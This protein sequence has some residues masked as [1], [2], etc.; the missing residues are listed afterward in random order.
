MLAQSAAAD[1]MAHPASV[2]TG[3]CVEVGDVVG[4]LSDVVGEATGGPAMGSA[5]A[6]AVEASTT[7]TV[8]VS[9][10]RVLSL[11]HSVV[12][13]RGPGDEDRDD[14]IACGDIGGH[15]MTATD[16]AIGLAGMDDSGYSGIATIHDNG[17]GTV[18]IAIFLTSAGAP[19]S[20]AEGTPAP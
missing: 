19:A 12:V 18:G 7:P 14:Y 20:E 13:A 2:R 15:E 8:P 17:D 6:I 1:L 3:S 9:Y 5:A 11:P 4:P 10:A 16:L